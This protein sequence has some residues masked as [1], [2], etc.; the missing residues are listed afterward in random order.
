MATISDIQPTASKFK[1]F[2]ERARKDFRINKQLYLIAVPLVAYYIIFHY[3]P[4]YGAIIAFED[5]SPAKGIFGSTWV[6]FRH[7]I[8]FFQG[9]YFSRVIINTL[10]ISINTLIFGFPAPI[11]LALLLNELKSRTFSRFVQTATY[12][13]HFV[14]MV[15][16]CGMIRE[17][18]LDT[19]VIND[20]L[21]LV[22]FDRVTML[23][24]PELFVPIYVISGI[25][26]EVGWGSIIYLATLSGI[27]QKLYEA[28]TIDGA[29][30]LKQTLHI[31][32]PGIMPTIIILFILRLG[33]LLDVGF[34]KIILLYNPII[35]E[36]ADVIS[37]Y[38][39]RK[40][41]LEFN[42]SFSTA[43]GMF[44]SVINFILL[45][46]ANWI[47]RKVSETSLW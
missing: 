39:Y 31:T 32:L 33:N 47:S 20:L 21:S 36:T 6:G 1:L 41:L 5:Y 37:S 8:D 34:E 38:V 24:V 10:F 46:S 27:D 28:A 29:G 18:T 43:V 14:S 2:R 42:W 9:F 11:I 13:P 19:G 4:M 26:K 12:M 35:Y 16:I 22:G 30:R 44:N 23:N 15:V 25:W 40:G 7:F 3:W 45:I 17:F